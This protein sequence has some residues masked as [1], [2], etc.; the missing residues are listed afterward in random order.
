MRINHLIIGIVA[1][2]T[3]LL[4]SCS[5]DCKHETIQK[6][7][8][9]TRYVDYWIEKDTIKEVGAYVDTLV[10]YSIVEYKY[11]TEYKKNSSGENISKIGTHYV[12]IKNN[13]KSYANSFAIKLVGKEYNESS[14]SWKNIDNR[15]RYVSINPQNT[16]TFSIKHSVWWRNESLGYDESDASISVLQNSTSVYHTT[17]QVRRMRQKL[18]R[19]IDELVLKDTI[20]NNCE[21]DIDALRAEYKAIQEVFNKLKKEN[22]IKT[23]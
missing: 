20:V 18:V 16:H 9:K 8:W 11:K 21:C 3:W 23:Q 17:K 10:S 15:T 22:F 13:N 12:T 2:A 7:E 1:M 5:P 4:S 6:P 14:K 19:R